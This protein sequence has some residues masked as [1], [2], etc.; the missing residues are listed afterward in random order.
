MAVCLPWFSV[1]S[2]QCAGREGGRETR[3]KG[4]ALHTEV[5]CLVRGTLPGKGLFQ[6]PCDVED[7]VSV[8][9][10]ESRVDNKAPWRPHI[11]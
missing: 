6:Q 3:K 11:Y 9:N 1:N 10:A 4:R 2:R 5:F 7:S 8:R